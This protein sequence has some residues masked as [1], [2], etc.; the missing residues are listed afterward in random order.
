M[1]TVRVEY[2]VGISASG[3]STY[4][5][6]Q[7]KNNGVV[8]IERD[9]IR[10]QIQGLDTG[11]PDWDTW[12]WKRE[13]EVSARQME[14]IQTY[15]GMAD[16]IIIADTNLDYD[17]L[18][19][20]MKAVGNVADSV[21][22]LVKFSVKVFYV[23][24]EVAWKR[25][26][27]RAHGVGHDV[28]YKQYLKFLEG[29]D[30]WYEYMTP[31][32]QGK[33]R[34]IKSARAQIKCDSNLS[35]QKAIIVDIDGTIASMDDIRGPFEWHRVHEDRVREEIVA[36]VH[37]LRHAYGDAKILV[38]SGRDGSARDLTLQWLNNDS[39]L[40]YDELWMRAAGDMRKDTIVKRELYFTHVFAQ[41]NV[42]KV[43]DDRPSVCRM[44]R[45]L[46]LDVIQ[47]ADPNEEF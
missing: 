44:W 42:V 8:V 28:I 4:A 19:A 39:G 46:G 36:L 20:H 17:R 23:D 9:S 40:D 3:K 15:L 30:T 31:E 1:K 32:D 21:G 5:K 33:V 16:K 41:Y 7:A 45:S 2:T 38:M 22:V 12:K 29:I 10:A 6:E 34:P 43:V 47:V 27:R 35:L 26:A 24:L 18:V 13:K 14:Y 37:G 25:D 11:R